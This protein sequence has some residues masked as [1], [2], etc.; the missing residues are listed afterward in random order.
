MMNVRD[1]VIVRVRFN[2]YF[3]ILQVETFP[4]ITSHVHIDVTLMPSLLAIV[5]GLPYQLHFL[6]PMT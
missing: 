3:Y 2:V 4:V 5:Y 6:V 1:I